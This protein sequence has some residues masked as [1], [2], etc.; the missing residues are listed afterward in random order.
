MVKTAV[1]AE[2]PQPEGITIVRTGDGKVMLY[3]PQGVDSL[4]L[5]INKGL[6]ITLTEEQWK[7]IGKASLS[8]AKGDLRKVWSEVSQAMQKGFLREDRKGMLGEEWI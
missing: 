4:R 5:L 1:G 2:E 3:F 7:Q 6:E 8:V